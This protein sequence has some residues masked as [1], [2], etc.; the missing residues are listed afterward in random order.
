MKKPTTKRMGRPPKMNDEE[1]AAAHR[2][3]MISSLQSVAERIWKRYSYDS[4]EACRVSIYKAFRKRG[5]YIHPTGRKG[6]PNGSRAQRPMNGEP[7]DG[8]KAVVSATTLTR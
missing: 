4:V 2:A 6:I 3:Y 5:L 8:E 1:I 7:C